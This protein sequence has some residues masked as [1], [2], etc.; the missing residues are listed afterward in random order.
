MKYKASVS[1]S[2][3]VTRIDLQI[4]DYYFQVEFRWQVQMKLWVPVL[5]AG[6]YCGSLPFQCMGARTAEYP[7]KSLLQKVN[8]KLLNIYTYRKYM[9]VHMHAHMRMHI[10]IS[11][12]GMIWLF[13]KKF[14]TRKQKNAVYSFLRGVLL[15]NANVQGWFAL[16]DRN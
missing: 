7:Y 11:I 2:E 14:L 5:K 15:M 8:S 10:H 9:H 3:N 1:V 13:L 12:Q 16:T 4:N 6:V